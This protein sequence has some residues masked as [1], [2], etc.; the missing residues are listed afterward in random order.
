MARGKA[1]AG[2][3]PR[4]YKRNTPPRLA[5]GP[6]HSERRVGMGPAR[7]RAATKPITGTARAAPKGPHV[8]TNTTCEPTQGRSS[9]RPFCCRTRAACRHSE[10]RVGM[11]P[12]RKRA[13]TKK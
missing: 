9:V 6:C 11:G 7:K 2:I 4:I 8:R 12:A 5:D 1:G 13:D 10:R 3:Y